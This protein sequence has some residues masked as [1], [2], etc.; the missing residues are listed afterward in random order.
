MNKL[1]L[2]D[3]MKWY[4]SQETQG[5][6]LPRIPVVVRLD[7]RSFSQFTKRFNRP[8]DYAFRSIMV[9]VTK[10]LVDKSNAVVGYTQSDEITLIL[11]T[12]NPKSD[13]FFKGRKFKLLSVLASMASV[14][15]NRLAD[16]SWPEYMDALDEADNLPVFDC[17]CFQVPNRDEAVN[18]LLWRELDATKNAIYMAASTCYTT[19]E[20]FRKNE[21]DQ[22]E[23]LFQKGINF[24]GYPAFFKRGTY[25]K[26]VPIEKPLDAETLAKIPADR[27][28]EK[29]VVMRNVLAE[30]S[31]PPLAKIDNRVA[32]VFDGE[33]V[34]LKSAV[35]QS[36]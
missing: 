23:M 10:S 31:L 25:V 29:G 9:E 36:A 12:N 2:G 35:T 1:T 14:R 32:V 24:N 8:I 15:F 28:P 22:Q 17:R 20:L 5:Q 13:L 33:E 4:E 7:G 26:K 19:Q 30:L 21:S 34:I 11:N 16:R 6:F 3:R 27:R 18:A